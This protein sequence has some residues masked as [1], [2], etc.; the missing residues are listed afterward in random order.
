MDGRIKHGGARRGF[1][2][3]L[4]AQWVAARYRAE[5][6][7]LRQD[8]AEFNTWALLNGY[9]D[10]KVLHNSTWISRREMVRKVHNK[11]W[12]VTDPNGNS[13]EVFGIQDLCKNHNLDPSHMTKVAKGTRTRHKG[14]K[15]ELI[16]KD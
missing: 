13:L 7:A 15:C 5:P 10:G 2:S 4:Y 6:I 9:T 8:F 12:L 1:R 11:L 3:A 14:W 16:S